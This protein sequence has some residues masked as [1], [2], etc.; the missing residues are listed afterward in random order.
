MPIDIQDSIPASTRRPYG[1]F[2]LWNYQSTWL[3]ADIIAGLTLAA[4]TIPVSMAY[5][6][7]AG[8]PAE[9]GIYCYLIGGA[10]YSL[11]GTSRQLAIGP[12]SAIAMLV[13]SVVSG[14]AEGDPARWMAIASLTALVVAIVSIIAW[15]L[16]LSGLMAFISETI[17][18][19]FKA[20]AALTIA[21]TQLPKLFGVPGGGDNFFERLGILATQLPQ[22]NLLVLGSGLAALVLLVAGDKIFPGRPVALVVVAL[23]ILIMSLTSL[24]E[25]GVSI[26]GELPQ[27]IPPF[28]LPSLRLRD[29]DGILPLALACF[30]LS[31]IEGI[32]AAR[33]LAAKNGY[34]IDPHQELLA[35]G[36]ANFSVAFAQGFP[37]AGGLS[38]SAVND[39]A[40]AKSPLALIVASVTLVVCLL[41][42]TGLLKNLPN[43]VLASI[44]LVAVK[45]LIDIP[46]LIHL[47]RVSRLEFQVALVALAG[48][49]LFGI[50][51][52]VLLATLFSLLILISAAARPNIA[53]L[54]RI[55]GSQRF[56]DL[57]RHPENE[58]VPGTLIFRVESS[59]LYFN[60]DYVRQILTQ[61]ISGDSH[62]QLVICDLSNSPVVDLAAARMLSSIQ[63]ELSTRDIHF[64]II[65]AHARN[66]DLLRTEG[67]EGKVGYLGRHLTIDQVI[68]ESTVS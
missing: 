66:R 41:F 32:S 40:G 10:A 26:V 39:K 58:Q 12:T 48:V 59:L 67:L 14:M 46:A 62:L 27:G 21:L 52:G 6:S 50:L 63:Q 60:T 49:L 37:V 17:L 11:F 53:F 51:K 4:Y 23:S 22:T 15:L 64:R 33:T 54:G 19:G 28:S 7:L 5:A 47:R 43:V 9:C 18:L 8:V 24:G 31:Y 2:W 57:A 42:L 25:R 13:G 1:L 36:A 34:E 56:S 30:L 29:V 55:A 65:D 16:R 3:T 20:G 68:S 61:K 35:L 38:Q 45:G 44:V